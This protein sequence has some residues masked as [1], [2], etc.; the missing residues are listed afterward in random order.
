MQTENHQGSVFLAIDKNGVQWLGF[1][2][3]ITKSVEN[4]RKLKM[5][6]SDRAEDKMGNKD[7]ERRDDLEMQKCDM[8]FEI[9]GTYLTTRV[10]DFEKRTVIPEMSRDCNTEGRNLLQ[11]DDGYTYQFKDPKNE[12]CYKK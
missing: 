1:P 6:T 4:A 8:K 5:L 10:K 11:H 7:H 9:C 12:E 3:R 2:D